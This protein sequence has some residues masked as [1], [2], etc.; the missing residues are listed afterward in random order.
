MYI[1]TYKIRVNISFSQS[2]HLAGNFDYTELSLEPENKESSLSDF[3]DTTKSSHWKPKG[4]FQH[5]SR[6]IISFGNNSSKFDFSLLKKTVALA[7]KKKK[8]YRQ[9]N[10][11]KSARTFSAGQKK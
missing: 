7:K 8:K 3:R 9:P 1:H 4:N 5:C 11:A 6:G 2:S 10:N